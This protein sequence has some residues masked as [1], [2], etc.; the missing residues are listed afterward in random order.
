MNEVYTASPAQRAAIAAGRGMKG[1]RLMT[2]VVSE[3]AARINRLSAYESYLLQHWIR[4]RILRTA[5]RR[6]LKAAYHAPRSTGPSPPTAL[7]PG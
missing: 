1:T 2:D 7:L 4:S 6:V 5:I 3:R